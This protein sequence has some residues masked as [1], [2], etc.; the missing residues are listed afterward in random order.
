MFPISEPLTTVTSYI[1]YE[2]SG[3][4]YESPIWA[5]LYDCL[6][7]RTSTCPTR[8][9]RVG[10]LLVPSPKNKHAFSIIIPALLNTLSG[11]RFARIPSF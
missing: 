5:R 2:V 10:M 4:Q 3:H 8:S 6:L 11:L 9:N 7:L 1:Q